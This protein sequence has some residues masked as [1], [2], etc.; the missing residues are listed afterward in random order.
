MKLIEFINN[1]KEID[2]NK[3][4]IKKPYSKY[5]KIGD[6]GEKMFFDYC[7]KN[8]LNVINMGLFSYILLLYGRHGKNK[9]D[10]S[11]NY[12]EIKKFKKLKVEEFIRMFSEEQLKFL[13]ENYQSL[14]YDINDK[15]TGLPD[16]FVWDN[17]KNFVFV[18]IKT[19]T[20]ILSKQQRE[21]IKKLIKHFSVYVCH[22]DLEVVVKDIEIKNI[23][24]GFVNINNDF[25]FSS[26]ALVEQIKYMKSHD[27]SKNKKTK[28]K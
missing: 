7:Q 8:N 19:G 17:D 6:I 9:S 15:K 3:K 21:V 10:Y 16:F 23:D 12:D 18:E 4:L 20:S 26:G 1:S 11:G 24:F 5:F 28:T 2:F 14:E 22:I 27:K 13:V 25:D